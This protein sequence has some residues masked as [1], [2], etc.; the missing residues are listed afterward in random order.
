MI[1]KI[2]EPLKMVTPQGKEK[3]KTVVLPG[4]THNSDVFNYS[5]P[6]PSKD[7]VKLA[8]EQNGFCFKSKEDETPT[9]KFGKQEVVFGIVPNPCQEKTSRIRRKSMHRSTSQFMGHEQSFHRQSSQKKQK[10]HRRTSIKMS[11]KELGFLNELIPDK[12]ESYSN[13]PSN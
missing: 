8:M 3:R 11:R 4:I 7:L 12:E 9:K 13:K 5:V 10:F 6:Q 2:T 1:D